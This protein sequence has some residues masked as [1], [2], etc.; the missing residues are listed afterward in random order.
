MEDTTDLK[1]TVIIIWILIAL[2]I[3]FDPP[4]WLAIL[5]LSVFPVLGTLQLFLGD[6]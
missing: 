2:L 3:I 1:I 5:W 4:S 6:I